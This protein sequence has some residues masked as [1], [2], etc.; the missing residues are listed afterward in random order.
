MRYGGFILG[1][2]IQL[3]FYSLPNYLFTTMSVDVIEMGVEGV[4]LTHFGITKK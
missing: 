1:F 2:K 4:N 3:G